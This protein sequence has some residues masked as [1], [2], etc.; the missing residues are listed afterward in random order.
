MGQKIKMEIRKS[1]IEEGLK[2][3]NNKIAYVH[4]DKIFLAFSNGEVIYIPESSLPETTLDAVI[5]QLK[6]TKANKN[7]VC[8]NNQQ[9][10]TLENKQEVKYNNVGLQGIKTRDELKIE[11][12][13]NQGVRS[14]RSKAECCGDPKELEL[15][16][17]ENT[18]RKRKNR[19]AKKLKETSIVNLR[20]SEASN[21]M[22]Q[23]Q[24]SGSSS[25]KH[26]SKYFNTVLEQP[27]MNN[28]NFIGGTIVQPNNITSD[29]NITTTLKEKPANQNTPKFI[30]EILPNDHEQ[31]MNTKIY[32]MS[33][34]TEILSTK[35]EPKR[36]P[37]RKIT[38][39][40]QMEIIEFNR[41]DDDMSLPWNI[42]KNAIDLYEKLRKENGTG[43]RLALRDE[44]LLKELEVKLKRCRFI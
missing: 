39:K 11:E 17:L 3:L 22:N 19:A 30:L 18:V 15:Y 5:H 35:E 38:A 21:I 8:V 24:W 7:V 10:A 6:K 33:G 23:N 32:N 36:N 26:E 31:T 40:E 29:Y 9:Y 42:I 34:I 44:E 20:C 28:I 25:L 13:K 2:Y 16:T 12:L 14:R 4:S 41:R 37:A 1:T 43:L 27:T